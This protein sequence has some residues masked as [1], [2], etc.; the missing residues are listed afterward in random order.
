MPQLALSPPPEKEKPA[1]PQ[2]EPPLTP[3]Q[4]EEEQWWA[5]LGD[6]AL[7]A[8]FAKLAKQLYDPRGFQRA[9]DQLLSLYKGD[10]DKFRTAWCL[11]LRRTEPKP[12]SIKLSLSQTAAE[13]ETASSDLGS[14]LA[15]LKAEPFSDKL[16][17]EAALLEQLQRVSQL[18]ED[19]SGSREPYMRIMRAPSAGEGPFDEHVHAFLAT[20]ADSLKRPGISIVGEALRRSQLSWEQNY[21]YLRNVHAA[22]KDPLPLLLT[23][24]LGYLA[25]EK[26]SISELAQGLLKALADAEKSRPATLAS[27]L[28]DEMTHGRAFRDFVHNE[29][30]LERRLLKTVAG[31]EELKLFVMW[32]GFKETFD[33]K[34]DACDEAS[35]RVL[36]GLQIRLRRLYPYTTIEVIFSDVHA[37]DFAGKSPEESHLYFKTLLPLVEKYGLKIIPLSKIYEKFS[38]KGKA[39]QLQNIELSEARTAGIILQIAPELAEQF[40][41]AAQ[42]HSDLVAR[43]APED[44]T[45]IAHRYLARRRFEDALLEEANPGAILLSFGDPRK[46]EHISKLP[47]V[48]MRPGRR[49]DPPWFTEQSRKK[50]LPLAAF[51]GSPAQPPEM[52]QPRGSRIRTVLSSVSAETALSLPMTSSRLMPL[53]EED[54]VA[55]APGTPDALSTQFSENDPV[56]A[57]ADLISHALMSDRFCRDSLSWGRLEAVAR[58]AAYD[59][60][61]SLMVFWGA[62][63][64]SSTGLADKADERTISHIKELADELRKAGVSVNVALLFNDSMP[65]VFCTAPGGTPKQKAGDNA[66]KYF[67]SLQ[68]IAKKHGVEVVRMSGLYEGWA[69]ETRGRRFRQK[70]IDSERQVAVTELTKAEEVK[71]KR[72]HEA[73]MR[74][75]ALAKKIASDDCLFGQ[76]IEMVWRNA[77][78]KPQR[79]EAVRLAQWYVSIH[80]RDLYFISALA[81]ESDAAGHAES[82]SKRSAILPENLSLRNAVLLSFSDPEWHIIRLAQLLGKQHHLEMP[83]LQCYTGP[84]TVKVPW[85][86]NENIMMAEEQ[87]TSLRKRGVRLEARRKL[88]SRELAGIA[89]ACHLLGDY[90]AGGPADATKNAQRIR[91]KALGAVL[92]WLN[93]DAVYRDVVKRTEEAVQF[94]GNKTSDYSALNS[95]LEEVRSKLEAELAHKVRWHPGPLHD[96]SEYLAERPYPY[97]AKGLA[98]AIVGPFFRMLPDK[99]R[100]RIRDFVRPAVDDHKPASPEA[101]IS[102][103]QRVIKAILDPLFETLQTDLR[104]ELLNPMLERGKSIPIHPEFKKGYILEALHR[105][106]K[107]LKKMPI[108][109]TFS[110]SYNHEILAELALILGVRASE[111]HFDEIM[112]RIREFEHKTSFPGKVAP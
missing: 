48:F 86:T 35:L 98:R 90:F 110:I 56:S 101:R 79:E 43:R 58:D 107:Y 57:R 77:K 74:A 16:V 109:D 69:T 87:I 65:P 66:Q 30:E 103:E 27:L 55:R 64:R 5:R 13:P 80:S 17:R 47:T 42:T 85:L 6:R 2:V 26:G 28:F 3:R 95:L 78:P 96:V 40:M 81:G 61:I 73:R 29:P 4:R 88:S 67:E 25:N 23:E 54:K 18:H 104:E 53:F 111:I 32:G 51:Q 82:A 49:S 38:G 52:R 21:F 12:Q 63:K 108:Q 97:A 14:L 37:F 106:R 45:K 105:L 46:E 68:P 11:Y 60:T 70:S 83:A 93:G 72:M 92:L 94:A 89:R 24:R 50:P 8:K 112:E 41:T 34:A 59:R 1:P 36:A 39:E 99:S 31:G 22:S 10:P 76:F 15:L 33:H 19:M 91:V 20:L 100:A 75:R 84:G 71:L 44:V 102:K 7:F 9:A 62:T